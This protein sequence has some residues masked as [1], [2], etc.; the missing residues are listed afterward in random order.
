MQQAPRKRR[1]MGEI[2]VVPLIDVML[3]L[4][5]IFMATAP[6]LTQGVQVDLPKVATN[7]LPPPRRPDPP[8]VLS[9]DAQARM[10]LNMGRTPERSLDAAALQA[11]VGRALAAA[12]ERDVLIKADNR[13]DYGRVLAAMVVLQQAG[14]SKIGFLTAPPDTGG[15]V[16]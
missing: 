1:L 14:A 6:L 13:V 7:P 15:R 5:V 12:P 3:V 10:F 9:I 8:L 4:L 11:A 16:P 2:N